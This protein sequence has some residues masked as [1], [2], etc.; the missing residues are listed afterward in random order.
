MEENIAPKINELVDHTDT[1]KCVCK[2]LASE[3]HQCTKHRLSIP[4]AIT[5][6]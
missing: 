4:P 2:I 6:M 1:Q 3:K 5:T